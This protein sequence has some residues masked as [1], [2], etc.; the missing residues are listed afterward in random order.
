[1]S[2]CVIKFAFGFYHF[3]SELFSIFMSHFMFWYQH[4]LSFS[5]YLKWTYLL[6]YCISDK[7]V[8]NRGS[9]L[10]GRI[11]IIRTIIRPNTNRIQ[12][13]ALKFEAM[14]SSFVLDNSFKFNVINLLNTCILAK[15]L[16]SLKTNSVQLKRH[17]TG[18]VLSTCE[19]GCCG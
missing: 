1:M 2:F 14:S 4:V 11:R 3:C 19:D 17:A 12:I 6:T 7:A 15:S 16:N 18:C 9:L 13:V 5:P 10:F 8:P